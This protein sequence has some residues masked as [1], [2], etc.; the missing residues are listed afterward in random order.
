V[1]TGLQP[2]RGTRPANR[3]ELILAAA[4]ELFAAR[5]YEHVGMVEIAG[6]VA[7]R[8]SA[9]YRHF[10]GKEQLLDEILQRGVAQLEVAVTSVDL[11]GAGGGLL[12]LAG[13]AIDHRDIG[14]LTGRELPHLSA[15]SRAGLTSALARVG[16][17]MA[18]KILSIRPELGPYP[19]AFLGSAALAVLSS[20]AFQHVELPRG[21]Y[22]AVV[23]EL[24]GRVVAARLPSEFTGE[25]VPRERAGL[26]AYSRREA[27]LAQAVA[28]FAER[29]YAGVGIED[30]AASL[31]MAGPSIYNHFRSKA[32]FLV[33]A[34]ERGSACLSVQVA[35][36]LATATGP[37][38]ALR[39]LIA[40]YAE[41]AVGHAAL[42]D[43]MISEVRSL[44]EPQREAAVNAQRDYVAE[45]VHLLRQAGAGL[46]QAGARVQVQAALTVANEVARAPHLR[47]QAGSAQAVAAVCEQMLGLSVTA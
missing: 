46:S 17:A 42:I 44:P 40:S 2:D 34:L 12:E 1:T 19:A 20:P 28:L 22:C 27:L 24:A 29:T 21:E 4:T 25:R 47:G 30:V 43:L 23:A 11:G 32:E 31:G 38:A 45:L 10:S 18:D 7:V 8:P 15:P 9:L 33:I 26:V 14:A 39:T 37:A 13:F 6:A 3:R 16:D 36:T 35:D 41:F 5:G